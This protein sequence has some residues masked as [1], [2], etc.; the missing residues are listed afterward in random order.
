[1]ELIVNK[2]LNEKL[3][4]R[5]IKYF[6]FLLSFVLLYGTN[7]T[8]V[9][10]ANLMP[11][12]VGVVFALFYIG[13]NGYVLSLLYFLAYILS[14]FSI[15]SLIISLNVSFVIA[16]L[17][18]MK[19]LGKIKLN[20]LRVFFFQVISLISFVLFNSNTPKEILAVV[21]SLILSIMFLYS[22]LCFFD[23]TFNKGLLGRIGLDEKICGAVVLLVFSIGISNARI[24]IISLGLFFAMLIILLFSHISK[25]GLSLIVGAVIGCGFSISCANPIYIS[26]FVVIALSAI[27]F[28]CKFRILSSIASILA[29]VL[30]VLI[31]NVGFSIGDILSIGFGGIIFCLI[32]KNILHA[33]LEA[34]DSNQAMSI[35]NI[36]TIEK[37]QITQRLN[38]LTSVFKEMNNVYRDMVK[39]NLSEDKAK[40]MLKE[41]VVMEICNN[42]S[43]KDN[44]F[45]YN[46]FMENCIN[47]FVDVSYE[48]KKAMLIDLPEYMS[49]NCIKI[50]Q[51]IMY[52][53]NVLSVYLDYREA[54][55]NIDTSR[56]LIADQLLGVSN[57]LKALTSEI[58]AEFL[59][60][61][62]Q[63]RLI[64]ENLA[65]EGVVCLDCVVC[66]KDINNKIITLIVKEMQDIDKKITKVVNKTLLSKYSIVAESDSGVVGTKEFVL[67]N[68]P[69]YSIVFGESVR[70][71]TG[72]K[73]SGDNHTITSLDDGKYMVSIC[74]GMGSGKRAGDISSLTISLIEDFYK[75][76]FDNEIILSSVNKLLSLSEY[77]NFSTID[78]CI[79]DGKKGLYDFIKLG[80]ASGY[81][82]R[83]TGEV[84]IISSSGLPVGV[85]EDIR[86]HI[87]KKYIEPMDIIILCSDG[88]TD[89]M[90][91]ELIRY[92]KLS[93][94]INPQILADEI[95]DRAIDLGGGVA[96]DD[97]TVVCVRVIENV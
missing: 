10:Y 3:K 22:C 53:N 25:Y 72:G 92:I 84:E 47:N 48:K 93:D 52:L 31:F 86:P 97:M 80:A 73:I 36:Y 70:T 16:V 23:S 54:I 21:V 35:K 44:C 89:I 51:L 88:I 17:E 18:Y 14:N 4:S 78:L 39:G 38:D 83:P 76:G 59:E 42:C 81:I 68:S 33:I 77:E 29:Y 28:K 37:N 63:A 24:A 2:F 5:V 32:P 85:L 91:E 19:T 74:D 49:T 67:K 82:K 60:D 43:S 66:E 61:K 41:D 34:F 46:S 58:G 8:Y 26:L 71:K 62:R 55:N 11:F 95:M 45:R 56:V 96:S 64:K 94:S 20:K 30:F 87:T 75:A 65:Y 12:G 27:A 7:N 13:F 1:M 90:G 50:N 57:L 79:V 6:V 9:Y 15:P 40:Q 69:K